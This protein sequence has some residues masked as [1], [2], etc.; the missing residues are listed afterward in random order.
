MNG[1]QL[2]TLVV[3]GDLPDLT[4]KSGLCSL[5]SI[6]EAVLQFQI[7]SWSYES[8]LPTCVEESLC[9]SMIPWPIL[10]GTENTHF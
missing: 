4:Y 2:E 3:S 5:V 6:D 9:S 1:V 8:S 7:G 10:V